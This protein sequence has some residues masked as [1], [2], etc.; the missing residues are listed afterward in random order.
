MNYEKYR[1]DFERD[2][3]VIV[4]NFLSKDEFKDLTD[5]LDRYIR[6]VVP[7]LPDVQ[8][9]Y[10]DNNRPETLKQL[11]SLEVDPYFKKYQRH[12]SWIALAEG[13]LGE[14]VDSDQAEWFNKPPGVEHPTPPHQDN[15]Y[16]CLKPPNVLT[17]WL[18]IDSVDEEN[19]CL[20]YVAGSHLRGVR[21]HSSNKVLGFSQGISD[22]GDEDV[23]REVKILLN[24]GDAVVHHGNTIHRADANRSSSR[25]RRAFAMVMKG[26]SCG[27]DEEAFT[28]YRDA[29]RAQHKELGLQTTI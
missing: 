28:R 13:L 6:E 20:R 12:P 26:K 27:R 16:F 3:Y 1:K 24:P 5:N 2:G 22:Y 23:A 29:V 9:Y 15:Y 21:P 10:H 18:A 25:N 7:K 11:Q 19:G 4:R 17:I 8:A 14:E